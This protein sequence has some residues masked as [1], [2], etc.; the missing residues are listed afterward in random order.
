MFTVIETNDISLRGKGA[1]KFTAALFLNV[2]A[3][4]VLWRIF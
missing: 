1:M 4:L 2:L 3:L